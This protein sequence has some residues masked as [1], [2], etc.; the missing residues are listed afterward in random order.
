VSPPCAAVIV[1]TTHGL[2]AQ[3]TRT[4]KI[5]VPFAAGGAADV[6]TRLLAEQIGRVQK[7]G[8]VVE[9]RPGAGTVTATEAVSRAVPDG[10]T[11]LINGNSFVINHHLRKLNYNPLTSFEPVCQLANSPQLI[12]VNDSSPY[13]TLADLFNAAR[14]KP[15]D[16]TMASV[17]P[18]TTQHIAIA[19][20]SRVASINLTYVPYPGD[21]PAINALL[22]GHVT[23]A[24]VNF[25]S[26]AEQ[27]STGKLRALAIA[28]R[29]RIDLLPNVPTVA[30][31]GY[32]DYEA[33]AWFGL[34]AP[35]RTPTETISQLASWLT[36]AMQSPQVRPKL[37]ALRLSPIGI[38]GADYG[39]YVRKQ[40]DAYGHA[41]R[42]ANIKAE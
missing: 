39:A 4:I 21:G 1:L 17:G 34:V 18:A 38:C 10:N 15:S 26:V 7:V 41:I 37:E 13:R 14:A 28:S 6:L 3:T 42:E 29:T 36:A 2:W 9:N 40:Y 5:I 32:K 24:F 11:L 19:V 35:A 30:E 23:S 27:V 25:S 12:V 8:T 20:L 31:L 16:L 33:E 22:G